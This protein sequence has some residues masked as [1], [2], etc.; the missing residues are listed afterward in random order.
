MKKSV[1]FGLVM[2]LLFLGGSCSDQW[3][4]RGTIS[5]L[6]ISYKKGDA[7]AGGAT[8]GGIRKT[9]FLELEE[10]PGT[11]FEMD[12]KLA[13]KHSGFE[14]LK[15]MERESLDFFGLL[16]VKPEKPEKMGKKKIFLKCVER[17]G[18]FEVLDFKED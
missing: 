8:V 6:G 5:K 12:L 11:I 3:T 18:Y 7:A 15:K 14:S 1:L 4:H 10:Y 16:G 17:Q 9:V 2:A 13:E